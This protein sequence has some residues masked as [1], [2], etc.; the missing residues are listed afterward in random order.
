MSERT[1]CARPAWLSESPRPATV[2]AEQAP[3]CSSVHTGEQTKSDMSLPARDAT[4]GAASVDRRQWGGCWCHT[5]RRDASSPPA[6][7]HGETTRVKQS[8][9]FLLLFLLLLFFSLRQDRLSLSGRVISWVWFL[10]ACVSRRSRTNV[11]FSERIA[12]W[13]KE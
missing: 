1:L 6:R 3:H 8:S 2:A 11:S 10:F 4:P 7:R 12:S 13:L 9:N 5:C